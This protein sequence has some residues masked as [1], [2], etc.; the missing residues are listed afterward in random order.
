MAHPLAIRAR[1]SPRDLAVVEGGEGITWSGLHALTVEWAQRLG[2]AGVTAGDRVAVV[3]PASIGFAALLHACVRLGATMAPL[4]PRA[5]EPA[6]DALL[7]E[8]RPRAVVRDGSIHLRADAARGAGELCV[9]FTSGT[10]GAPRPVSLTVD[11]HRASAAGLIESIG[12][13]RDDSWLLMLSPHHVGGFAIFMRSVLYGQP[14]V[15][16]PRFDVDHVIAALDEHRPT[17]VSVVPSMLTRLLDAGAAAALRRPRAILVGG[18]PATGELVAEWSDLGLLV[19]PTYG[20]TETCSQV[21]TVP[22][23]RALDLLGTSG[24]VHSQASVTI[25]GGVIAVSGPVVSPAFGGRIVTGDLG[26]FDERGALIVT[27]R[28]DDVIVTGGEKVHPTEVERTLRGHPAVR[29]VAVVG[30]PDRVYGTVLEALV[31]GD[32]VSSDALIEWSR[33]RLPSFKVPRRVRFV[34][35]LPVSEGG[36]LLRKRL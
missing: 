18:A 35:S 15:A 5:P 27:G 16:L 4:S 34:E 25:E 19:C 23:G 21:A 9:L 13:R 12:R 29:E 22:P 14:V 1:R 6:R 26:H 8:L 20:M 30:R 24:F 32:G 2:A 28:R 36:K 7:S 10:T 3:E 31:V 11:N 33:E 17:L